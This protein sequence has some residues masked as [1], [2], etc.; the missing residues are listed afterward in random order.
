MHHVTWSINS[1]CHFFGARRFQTDDYSTNVFWLSLPSL[2]EAW[3]HNHHAFPRSA[4]HGLRWYELDPSGWLIS[5]SR[6]SASPGTSSVTRP[7]AGS[8]PSSAAAHGAG[9]PSATSAGALGAPG[10][11]RAATQPAVAPSQHG[12][13]GPLG[14]AA[15]AWRLARVGLLRLVGRR[16]GADLARVRRPRATSP[17]R[18]TPSRSQRCSAPAR[19]ITVSTWRPRARRWMRRLDHSMIYVLIAAATRRSRCSRSRAA[20][21]SS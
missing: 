10:S 14:Q 16:A 8:A 9:A 11:A 21:T 12:R 7:R 15:A 3:H 20:R 6:S 4:F 18:S 5:R 2:G 17:L 1:I 19:S 13:S